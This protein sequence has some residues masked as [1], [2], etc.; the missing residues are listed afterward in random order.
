[1]LY[2]GFQRD[3]SGCNGSIRLVRVQLNWARTVVVCN[4]YY[5]A[6]RGHFD[7]MEIKYDW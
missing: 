4:S 6:G 1:M 3:P 7:G 5:G 2:S